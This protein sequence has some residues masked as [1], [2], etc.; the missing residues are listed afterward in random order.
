MHYR[1]TLIKKVF[2]VIHKP[3]YAHTIHTHTHTHTHTQMP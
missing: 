3:T 2:I 1:Y